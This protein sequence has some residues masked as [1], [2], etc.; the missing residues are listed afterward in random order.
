MHHLAKVSATMD[1]PENRTKFAIVAPDQLVHGLGRMYQTYRATAPGSTKQVGV[2]HTLPEAMAFLGIEGF[3]K[4]E[5]PP[6]Q[7]T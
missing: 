6:K 1:S 5:S 7:V 4:P 3:E 2:F